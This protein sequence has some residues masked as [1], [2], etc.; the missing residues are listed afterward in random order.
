MKEE[1]SRREQEERRKRREEKRSRKRREK[2]EKE[3]EAR[4]ALRIAKE[5]RKLLLAQRKLESIRLLSEVLD[6]VKVPGL[7]LYSLFQPWAQLGGGHGRR[8]PPLFQTVGIEYAMSPTF[9]S[10]GFVI[11]YF[12]TK[13][14]P[15]HFT[16]ILRS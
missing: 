5:E 11:Y 2:K 13:P 12:H 15:S 8:V 3:Q 16:T 4:L 14:S 10:L 7:S 6:R 9:F 1:Q